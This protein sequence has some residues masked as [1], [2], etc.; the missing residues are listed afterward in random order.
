MLTD[1]ASASLPAPR[2]ELPGAY[3]RELVLVASRF[4][5]SASALLEGTGV[6]SDA[7]ED[8]TTRLSL[9][10]CETLVARALAMTGEPALALHV[11]MQMRLSSHGFLGFAA[12]TAPRVREALDLAERFSLTRTTA[13]GLHLHVHGD[14]ASIVLEEHAPLGAL[15]EFLV[16]TLFV[17]IAQ[18]CV[19]IT[20][21][22]VKGIAECTFAEP[23]W[24]AR[25]KG[26]AGAFGP[27]RFERPHNRLV[28]DASVLDLPLVTADP[29]AT[30][31]AR[32]Q[33]E[34]EL[35]AL[36]EADDLVS[37]VRRAVAAPSDGFQSQA[38]VAK[39]LHVSPRTLKRR[40]AEHGTTF[41]RVLDTMRQQRALLLLEH[42]D[43][44]IDEIAARLGYS[45][46][47]N[48][49]RA[50]KRWTN[51][52]PGKVRGG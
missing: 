18:L 26:V 38:D 19:S 25:S 52:T 8:P 11:G 41:T 31:L 43:T 30:Q 28:F 14:R 2:S 51:T 50:F 39:A 35:A 9:A 17:G 5:V 15:R 32:A 33:C 21:K 37:L 49:T 6:T 10:T 23:R 46:V 27:I 36:A 3:A 4:G 34:K 29:V 1:S 22:T 48:F 47:A 24:I 12:M 13:F 7:L 45:D 44:T 20:G 40:L 42:R 16:L